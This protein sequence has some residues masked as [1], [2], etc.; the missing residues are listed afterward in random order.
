MKGNVNALGTF[1]FREYPEN[2]VSTKEG[3]IEQ[4]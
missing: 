2:F 1:A 4:M 3:V